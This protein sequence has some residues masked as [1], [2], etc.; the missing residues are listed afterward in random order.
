MTEGSDDISVNINHKFLN[1]FCST[2]NLQKH[3]H[4]DPPA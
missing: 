1:V 3:V 4:A 2:L